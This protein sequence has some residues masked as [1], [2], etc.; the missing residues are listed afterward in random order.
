MAPAPHRCQGDVAIL[1]GRIVAVGAIPATANA[2]RTIDATGLTVAPGF[3]D[4]H[5]HAAEGLAGRMA[6]AMPLLA[7]GVDHGIHQS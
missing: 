2:T 1:N 3:I 5:S 4:V 7:Q 6:D